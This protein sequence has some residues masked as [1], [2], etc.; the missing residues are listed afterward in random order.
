MAKIKKKLT[1]YNLPVFIEPCEEGGYFASCP[2]LAGC[3]VEAETIP[4]A[5][6]YLEDTVEQF[7]KSY[8]KHGDP[9]PAEIKALQ[10]KSA[11]EEYFPISLFLPV[12]L[13]T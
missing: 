4:Q 2:S 3:F 7:I 8:K 6:E 11:K 1:Q 10:T 9:L 13:A 12:R 5:I